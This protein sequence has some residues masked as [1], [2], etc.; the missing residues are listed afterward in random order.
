[1]D[2]MGQVQ[3]DEAGRCVVCG[4]ES[5]FRFD[6]TIIAS[7]LKEVWGISDRLAE[8]FNRKENMFCSNCGCSLRI[9]WLAAVLIQTFSEI[10]G[11][12]LQ[13]V[14]GTVGD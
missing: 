11:L 12:V 4:R 1:M 10:N 2:E 9:R 14:R 8:A 13:V 6:P 7:Q 3:K 5:V